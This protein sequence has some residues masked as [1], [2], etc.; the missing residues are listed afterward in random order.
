[1]GMF[2]FFLENLRAFAGEIRSS[3]FDTTALLVYADYLQDEGNDERAAVFLR[4]VIKEPV[5]RIRSTFFGYHSR[6]E[7]G[8]PTAN[9]HVHEAL[10]F[11]QAVDI[12]RSFSGLRPSRDS[13]FKSTLSGRR[14]DRNF[15]LRFEDNRDNS[16]APMPVVEIFTLA[17]ERDII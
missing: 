8:R 15:E 3:N 1:M 5:L 17:G 2:R 16:E 6:A 4:T 9:T 13:Y 7:P 11:H 10:T 14:N 12:C